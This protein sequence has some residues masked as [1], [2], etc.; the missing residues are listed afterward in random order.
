MIT[1]LGSLKVHDSV[2]LFPRDMR[3]I[4]TFS[5]GSSRACMVILRIYLDSLKKIESDGPDFINMGELSIFS[6]AYF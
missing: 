1:Y 2:A 5:S 6:S 4:T 3:D